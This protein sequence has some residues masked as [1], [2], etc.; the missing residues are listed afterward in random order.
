MQ[1]RP[2]IASTKHVYMVI[3]D[4]PCTGAW[5]TDPSG[6]SQGTKR[7][8]PPAHA[9]KRWAKVLIVIVGALILK[10]GVVDVVHYFY[11]HAVGWLEHVPVLAR[12][13]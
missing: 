5:Q 6:R 1:R 13:H 12:R 11:P 8:A 9:M 2:S 10:F 7:A 3:T 4:V